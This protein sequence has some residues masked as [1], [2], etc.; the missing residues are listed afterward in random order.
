M[1]NYRSSLVVGRFET[2]SNR[3]ES[4]FRFHVQFVIITE[5]K[6]IEKLNC[7]VLHWTKQ[8]NQK[9]LYNQPSFGVLSRR[10]VQIQIATSKTIC[11]FIVIIIWGCFY[12]YIKYRKWIVIKLIYNKT[13]LLQ[14]FIYFHVFRCLSVVL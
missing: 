10:G 8:N 13:F 9:S 5:M 1:Y 14:A 3:L 6:G 7:R 2:V 11:F 12:F 4:I